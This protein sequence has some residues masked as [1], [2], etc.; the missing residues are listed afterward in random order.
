M[1]D[2]QEELANYFAEELTYRRYKMQ[3]DSHTEHFIELFHRISYK[4]KN[5]KQKVEYL[6]GRKLKFSHRN[7][8]YTVCE[9]SNT[10]SKSNCYIA[11]KFFAKLCQDRRLPT[12]IYNYYSSFDS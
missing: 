11:F 5:E 1:Q 8:I 3:S 6:I 7:S 10:S 9:I 12:Y 2:V 4:K